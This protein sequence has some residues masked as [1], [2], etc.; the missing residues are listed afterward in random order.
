M[1]RRFDGSICN[2]VDLMKVSVSLTLFF[3]SAISVAADS[4]VVER[5]SPALNKDSLVEDIG[6]E[7]IGGVLTPL[8]KSGCELPCALTQVFSTA[9]DNQDQITITLVRGKQKMVK[10]NVILG[11]YRITGIAPAP[12]GTPQIAVEL[13]AF[14]D[15]IHLSVR[16]SSNLSVLKIDAIE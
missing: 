16:D 13:K 8:L 1:R 6:I 11:R 9:E 2:L 7:T 3:A 4:V 14:A 10:Q 15:N 12:R 5:N